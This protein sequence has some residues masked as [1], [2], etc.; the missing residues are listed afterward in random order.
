MSSKTNG[1]P[2]FPHIAADGHRDY[3]SGLTI[4]DWFAGQVVAAAASHYGFNEPG[5]DMLAEHAYRV[6][7]AMIRERGRG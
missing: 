2:A 1:G 4:R 5:A 3:H 7:D 6:A